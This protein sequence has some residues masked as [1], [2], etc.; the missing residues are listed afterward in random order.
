MFWKS[1]CLN[2]RVRRLVFAGNKLRLD[3]DTILYALQPLGGHRFRNPNQGTLVTVE[4]DSHQNPVRLFEVTVGGDE[5]TYTTAEAAK[6]ILAVL[7]EYVGVYRSAELDASYT[8]AR[9]RD[10]LV[11]TARKDIREDLEPTIRD[12]FN[13][14]LGHLWFQRSG[15]RAIVRF[16]L[17]GERVRAM[18]FEKR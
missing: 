5:E 13:S 6:P 4:L 14:G 17:N 8:V 7:D 1:R 18:P 15:P 10:H 11:L 2:H 9:D 16:V 3:V 12:G